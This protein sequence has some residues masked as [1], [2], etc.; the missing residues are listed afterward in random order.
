MHKIFKTG[1]LLL[2]LAMNASNA[3][4]TNNEDIFFTNKE[5]LLHELSYFSE[6]NITLSPEYKKLDESDQEKV[7]DIT[8]KIYHFFR[9]YILSE[10]HFLEIATECLQDQIGYLIMKI[11][12]SIHYKDNE[13]SKTIKSKLEEENLS[14]EDVKEI[15]K[16]VVK[17]LIHAKYKRDHSY[18]DEQKKFI[19]YQYEHIDFEIFREEIYD[20]SIELFYSNFYKTQ[21]YNSI[22]WDKWYESIYGKQPEDYSFFL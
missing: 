12:M 15:K 1:I 18:T 5:D 2:T 22:L 21:N 9:I 17:R 13:P 14:D 4:T 3:M 11:I 16:E 8:R 7:K 20:L 6:E 10:R 19:K